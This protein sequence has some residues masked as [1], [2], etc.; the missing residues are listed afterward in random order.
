M[1]VFLYLLY[2]EYPNTHYASKV[3]T[4]LEVR[5][6]PRNLKGLG[7][8]VLKLRAF[9][10]I[11]SGMTVEM[12]GAPHQLQGIYLHVFSLACVR[13]SEPTAFTACLAH[14]S[15]HWEELGICAC[16]QFQTDQD[17][18]KKCASTDV[19]TWLH[20]FIVGGYN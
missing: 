9:R 6:V 8:H 2:S 4:F 17:V 16:A 13:C 20:G 5:T 18:Q 10:F 3:W 11:K 19:H 7:P 12:C 14:A 15:T 1:C